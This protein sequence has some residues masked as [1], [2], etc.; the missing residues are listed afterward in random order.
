MKGWRVL[1]EVDGTR[2]KMNS[3]LHTLFVETKKRVRGNEIT[4]DGDNHT[5]FDDMVDP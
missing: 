3:D 2:K 5:L 4:S 1:Q